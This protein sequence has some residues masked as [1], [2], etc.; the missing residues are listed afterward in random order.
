MLAFALDAPGKTLLVIDRVFISFKSV[1]MLAIRAGHSAC[2]AGL[3][4]FQHK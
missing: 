4:L 2:G 3:K 1:A